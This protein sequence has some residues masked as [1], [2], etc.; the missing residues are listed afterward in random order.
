MKQK[1]RI[2]ILKSFKVSDLENP[3]TLLSIQEALTNIDR[4]YKGIILR[5]WTNVL[6]KK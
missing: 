1:K 6:K 4:G 5:T 3:I 2:Q